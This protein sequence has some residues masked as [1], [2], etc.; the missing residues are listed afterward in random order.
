MGLAAL[1]LMPVQLFASTW[2]LKKTR[3]KFSK[4]PRGCSA[5]PLKFS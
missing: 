4:L 5:V 3:S 1:H 2:V